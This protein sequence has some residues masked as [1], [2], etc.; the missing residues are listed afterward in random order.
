MSGVGCRVLTVNCRVSVVAILGCRV[1]V[2]GFKLLAVQ[3]CDTLAR[4]ADK[5]ANF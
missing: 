3:L 1:S 4:V 5:L 2:V